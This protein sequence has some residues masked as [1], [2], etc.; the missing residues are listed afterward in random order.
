MSQLLLKNGT[1]V[2]LPAIVEEDYVNHWKGEDFT[3]EMHH[4]D[5][6]STSSS[7]LKE[8]TVSPY[9]YL[10]GLKDK[11]NGLKREETKPMRFGTLCHMAILEPEKFRKRFV[12]SPKFDLRTTKGKEGK[13]IFDLELPAGAIVMNEDE[14]DNLMGVIEAVLNHKE[15]RHIF[16]EGVTE[17]SGYFRDPI[18]GILQRI[19]PDFMSTSSDLNMF[20]DFKTAR[21]SSYRGFQSQIWALRYDLQ[22]AMYR[23]GIKQITGSYPQITGWIAVENTRPNEI[24]IYPFDKDHLDT[25][26][27][28]YRYCLDKL[29]ECIKSK[30]FHQRQV[31]NESMV[32]PDYAVRTEIPTLEVNNG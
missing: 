32:L 20:I 15:A 13:A 27:L 24:A 26:M 30:N 1:N 19:R 6:S 18:T 5:L 8:I 22:L 9:T 10:S 16:T 14:Y 4:A 2:I 23:E 12:M 11:Q 17:R 31:S 3:N 25:A 29:A 28:W 7:S 21:D